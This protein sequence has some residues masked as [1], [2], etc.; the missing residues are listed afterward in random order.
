[1]ARNRIIKPEFWS[2]AKVGRLSFGARLLYIAMWNFA[3]DCG[4]ISASPRRLLGDAFEN[5]ESVQ[6]GDVIGWL[7]EIEAQQIERTVRSAITNGGLIND[8]GINHVSG[9]DFQVSRVEKTAQTLTI[10]W[11]LQIVPLAKVLT[12]TGDI[13]FTLTIDDTFSVGTA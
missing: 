3:D 13:G 6:I 7:A 2:D 1:M 5:D 4:T 9:F 10:V 12:L 11:A 8:Q